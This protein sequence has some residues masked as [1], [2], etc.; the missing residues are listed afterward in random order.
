M[1]VQ[2]LHTLKHH[3]YYFEKGDIKAVDPEDG[4]LFVKNGWCI[5]VDANNQPIDYGLNQQS[6]NVDLAIDKGNIGLTDT[7]G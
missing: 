2:A 3:P 7:R 4:A 5:Q 1:R 6:E